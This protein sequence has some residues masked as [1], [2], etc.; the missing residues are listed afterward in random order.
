MGQCVLLLT[1]DQINLFTWIINIVKYNVCFSVADVTFNCGHN[2]IMYIH[3]SFYTLTS[4][5]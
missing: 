2:E 3:T 4:Y 5:L 1:F